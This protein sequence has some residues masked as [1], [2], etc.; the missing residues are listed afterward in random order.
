MRDRVEEFFTIAAS[1]GIA[2]GLERVEAILRALG[3][4]QNDLRFIH[5]AGTNGKGS[6]G[7]FCNAL[8]AAEGYRVGWFSTPHLVN[9]NESIRI[10]DGEAGLELLQI[11]ET[12]GE[13]SWSAFAVMVDELEQA[14][15]AIQTEGLTWPSE[16]EMMTAAAILHFSRSGCDYV[17]WETGMG[18]TYDAT[19]I[20]DKPVAVIITALG[21]DHASWLG[22]DILSV[23]RHKAGIIKPDGFVWLYDPQA[24]LADS[25][26]A[27]EVLRLIERSCRT[28]RASLELVTAADFKLIEYKLDGQV[29]CELDELGNP[30]PSLCHRISMTGSYQPMLAMLAIRACCHVLGGTILSKR[31]EKALAEAAW[32]AR[33]EICQ[34]QTATA[35]PVILDGAHN[36]QGCI[37]LAASLSE[38]LPDHHIVFLTGMLADKDVETMLRHI[39]FEQK[40][41]IGAIICTEAQNAR[42]MP[43]IELANRIAKLTKRRVISLPISPDNS[44]NNSDL[45]IYEKNAVRAAQ[46]ALALDRDPQNALCAF[47]SLYLAGAVRK[48]LLD[49]DDE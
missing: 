25:S 44:Y 11:D 41:Q 49:H 19:N 30:L 23:A 16:F 1:S 37:A 15:T 27:D 40:Y 5:I 33:F 3:N 34:P 12:A 22:K 35:G 2:P 20:I 39:F 14:A 21:L 24:A 32:P 10:T 38:L 46:F 6:T 36:P 18:G 45:V 8:L 28:M 7:C 17:V 48:H 31:Q 26:E 42:A 29:F 47:G 43:A 13:I 9:R 4:P